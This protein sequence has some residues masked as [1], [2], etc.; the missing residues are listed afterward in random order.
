MSEVILAL[1]AA[2]EKIETLHVALL[3]RNHLQAN[4]FAIKITPE[5][6]NTPIEELR[7]RHVDL[8]NLTATQILFLAKEIATKVR[9][10][11]DFYLFTK[12]AVREILCTAVKSG[13]LDL[14]ILGDKV[15]LEVQNAL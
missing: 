15:R 5:N 14:N 4:G 9:Q 2:M 7:S 11:S 13:R 6:A 12:L 1:A 3:D 8:T 10:N